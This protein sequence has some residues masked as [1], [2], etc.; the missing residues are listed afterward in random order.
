MTLSLGVL[1]SGGGRTILNLLDYIDRGDLD[2]T[3]DIAIA[4]RE[5]ISGIDR[6]N[7]RGLDVAIAKVGA[8]SGDEADSRT[9]VWLEET[10]PDLICLCGYLR[11]LVIQPW[12]EG[13]ALNILPALLPAHGEKG[14][15]G[16]RVHKAVLKSGDLTS[17]CTVHLVDGEYD[18]GSTILQLTCDVKQDDSPQTLAERV[19]SLE[20]EAYPEAI[21]QLVATLQP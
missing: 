10:K 3:I 13:R 2:A 8:M 14:M 20:C 19:F 21:K 5:N 12:M 4:S 1:F 18:H 6:L 16:M 9:N 15:Y 11:L 17:G 7:E